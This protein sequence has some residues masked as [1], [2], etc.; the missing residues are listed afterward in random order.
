MKVIVSRIPDEMYDTL[1]QQL[2]Q[3]G[4]TMDGY[5]KGLVFNDMNPNKKQ[6]N[7]E[8][9]TSEPSRTICFRVP[10]NEY[11]EL[12]KAALNDRKTI[13]DFIKDLVSEDLNEETLSS[14]FESEDTYG[15]T[16]TV[17]F[18]AG[19]SFFD[20]VKVRSSSMDITFQDY[21]KS[22]IYSVT[23]QDQAENMSMTPSMG[24]KL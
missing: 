10:E 9:T 14:R 18:Q 17:S 22:V 6:V 1:K 7:S 20:A 16:R 19:K 2:A 3:K 24:M 4:Q 13:K 23:H 8:N 21:M 11:K 15:R 12:Q 5:L